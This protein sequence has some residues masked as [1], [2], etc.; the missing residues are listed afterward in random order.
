MALNPEYK[1]IGNQMVKMLMFYK[2]TV[3]KHYLCHSTNITLKD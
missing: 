1:I 2:T 3:E